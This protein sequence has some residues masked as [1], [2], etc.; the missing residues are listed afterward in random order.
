MIANYP[1]RIPVCQ[2]S[3][4]PF[5]FPPRACLVL[6]SKSQADHCKARLTLLFLTFFVVSMSSSSPFPLPF[7]LLYT[8][9]I[10]IMYM[11]ILTEPRKFLCCSLNS[12][13]VGFLNSKNKSKPLSCSGL[14]VYS[15]FHLYIYNGEYSPVQIRSVPIPL[16]M[17]MFL[18]LFFSKTEENGISLYQ[19]SL[20]SFFLPLLSLISVCHPLLDEQSTP[21][22][23]ASVC[24]VIVERF[25]RSNLPQME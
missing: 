5:L 6:P 15:G 18:S 2:A 22:L 21:K 17:S 13:T 19:A 14:M 16:V 23:L 20:L 9:S 7:V 24:K 25:S 4:S 8:I 3:L 10:T 12:Q 1:A 11:L